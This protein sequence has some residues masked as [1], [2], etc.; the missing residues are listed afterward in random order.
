MLPTMKLAA[1]LILLGPLTLSASAQGTSSAAPPLIAPPVAAL[2][3]T[4]ETYS[5]T[6]LHLT[7]SYPSEMRPEDAHA[8]ADAG[9][10]AMYG[11]QPETDPEHAKSEACDKVL[12]MVGKESDP[13]KREVTITDGKSKPSVEVKPDPGGSI[14][15]FE[16]DSSCLPPKALKDMD[17]A[18]A[19]LALTAT[20][21][22]GMKPIDKP[23]WY[24]IQ[25]H[26]VHFAAATGSPVAKDNKTISPDPQIIAGFA[27]N[28]NGHILYWML[29]SND[30]DFFN[31]LLDSKV[32][33]G[34]GTPQVLFPEH[35]Q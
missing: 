25:G 4:S 6:D 29:Q 5:N 24:E 28:M 14:S 18:L 12:L 33:F 19:G 23:V 30:I 21:I 35:L 8:I 2:N 22:P 34:S 7:F 20:E 1:I 16:I 15:L 27:V 17:N 9:H 11:T 10:I 26:K 3:Q 32:D 13:K 31:H